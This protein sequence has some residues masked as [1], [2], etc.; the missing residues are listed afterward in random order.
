MGEDVAVGQIID[1]GTESDGHETVA[2]ATKDGCAAFCSAI[3]KSAAAPLLR[4]PASPPR[5]GGKGRKRVV[6]STR[7]SVRL[8]ARPSPFPVAQR[9]QQKLIWELQFMDTPTL[10]PD[11]AVTEYVDLYGQDLPEDAI[12]A[13]RAATHMGNKK[14]A[15]V[16]AVMAAEAGAAQMEVA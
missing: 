14:L 11:A 1:E 10:A 9:A 12:K 2:A 6:T 15:K 8:A 4:R 13:I 7:S 5:R 3:F 16:L